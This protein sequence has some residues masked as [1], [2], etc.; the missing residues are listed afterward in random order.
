MLTSR[1]RLFAVGLLLSATAIQ[2]QQATTASAPRDAQAV[3]L[4]QR[5]LA[6]L[7]GTNTIRDVTLSGSANRIAGSDDETG[8]VTL[9]ATAVGQG[10]ID[11]S[12]SNGSRLEVRD[13]ST[14]HVTGS[15]SG[16]EGISHPI[17]NHN[18][19]SD[20]TWF[21]PAFLFGRILSDAGYAISAP[22]SQKLN[23]LQVEHVA[24]SRKYSRALPLPAVVQRLYGINL[25]INPST[26]LPVAIIF[27]THP[28]T[29]ALTDIP[30]R[31]EFSGYRTT[32]AATVPYR[33]K[34]YVQNGLALDLA[35]TTVVFN[36]GP[37]ATE[38]QAQ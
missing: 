22:D 5:S 33:I 29:D 13:T 27:N 15:W 9:K 30:V 28:D 35:I 32:Q 8:T 16:P 11:L 23:G 3:V 17:A 14:S 7:V 10:R 36:S 21:F 37:S 4:L 2:A 18:L 34:R 20:P 31:I 12:L 6:V 26:L 24:I 38:F 19:C 1:I 25:Y